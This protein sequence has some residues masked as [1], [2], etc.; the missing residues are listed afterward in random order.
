[1]KENVVIINA[2]ITY[3]IGGDLEKK[4]K[5]EV[6]ELIKEKLGAEDVVVKKLK[7]FITGNEE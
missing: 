6:A 7:H 2:D 4:S 5:K 3:I 1:M